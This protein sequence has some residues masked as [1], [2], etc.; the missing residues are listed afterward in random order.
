[1]RATRDAGAGPPGP[2]DARGRW[3]ALTWLL[4]RL[5]EPEAAP[6]ESP[7][8]ARAGVAAQVAALRARA[9]G[10]AAPVEAVLAALTDRAPGRRAP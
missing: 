10:R 4:R 7:A 8:A 2:P 9:P 3:T 5:P 1:M 6:R